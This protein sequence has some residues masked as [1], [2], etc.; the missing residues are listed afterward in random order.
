MTILATPFSIKN[1]YSGDHEFYNI[2]RER[3]S[4]SKYAV[5]CYWISEEVKTKNF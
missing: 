2:D 1:S 4:L 5:S 3:Y